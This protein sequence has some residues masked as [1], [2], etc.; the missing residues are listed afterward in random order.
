M[1]VRAVLND[2]NFKN[3][4][5]WE[6]FPNCQKFYLKTSNEGHFCKNQL[7]NNNFIFYKVKQTNLS[8]IEGNIEKLKKIIKNF[9]FLKGAFEFCSQISRKSEKIKFSPENDS[10]NGFLSF[11]TKNKLFHQIFN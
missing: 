1:K 3:S 9:I 2:K 5:F 4:S 11:V 10:N 7:K 8:K 6:F